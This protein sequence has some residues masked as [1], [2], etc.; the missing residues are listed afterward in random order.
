VR[1]SN[2]KKADESWRAP[3]AARSTAVMSALLAL[4]ALAAW[5]ANGF[6]V[7]TPPMRSAAQLP[8]GYRLAAQVDLSAAE[9]DEQALVNFRLEQET[10][11]GIYLIVQGINTKYFDVQIHETQGFSKVLFHGEG[12]SAV[13]DSV[14]YDAPLPP[15][16]YTLALTS[17]QSPG[18]LLVYRRTEK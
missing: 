7:T 8:E 9:N 14:A 15:G 18:R 13:L 12:Y 6:Q 1:L 10:P 4:A 16:D 11:A 2:E 3:G 17:R 5:W